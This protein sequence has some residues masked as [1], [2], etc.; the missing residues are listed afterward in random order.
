[1]IKYFQY[2]YVYVKIDETAK[3]LTKVAN[4]DSQKAISTYTEAGLYNS[5]IQKSGSWAES[6]A[7]T[8]DSAKSEVITY[9]GSV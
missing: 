5:M 1:M 4:S 3:L 9:L 2:D 7:T 6:D 8:F